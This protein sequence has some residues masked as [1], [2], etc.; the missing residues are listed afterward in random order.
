MVEIVRVRSCVSQQASAC[1]VAACRGRGGRKEEGGGGAAARRR[2]SRERG[3][4]EDGGVRCRLLQL[5][6][7]QRGRSCVEGRKS[8]RERERERKHV[9]CAVSCRQWSR[10]MERSGGRA[11]RRNRREGKA[12]RNAVVVEA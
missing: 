2:R 6:V 5:P 3:R 1:R 8:E 12:P 7:V 10:Y 11:R 9:G 4:V